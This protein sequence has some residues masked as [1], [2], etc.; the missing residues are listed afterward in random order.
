LLHS[1]VPSAKLAVDTSMNTT[2]SSANSIVA[3]SRDSIGFSTLKQQVDS[4][5]A[6]PIPQDISTP[7]SAVPSRLRMPAKTPAQEKSFNAAQDMST[8]DILKTP[9]SANRS[10][11]FA[12]P[13]D[14]RT[15]SQQ[16][17][18]FIPEQLKQGYVATHVKPAVTPDVGEM[19]P[20]SFEKYWDTKVPGYM[21]TPD[22]PYGAG[23]QTD[24]V[25]PMTKKV[26]KK[27]ADSV[28]AAF[29][30][31]SK[32]PIPTYT[33][34]E[35]CNLFKIIMIKFIAQFLLA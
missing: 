6:K 4:P 11:Q 17:T 10:V 22:T 33:A 25:S 19:T 32:A 12:T 20:R 1:D 14:V 35:V 28:P 18:P 29:K 31:N 2:L 16:Y 26:W 24:E 21:P 9:D 15:P 3:N 8:I 13:T 34:S 23:I 30:A 27:Y 5:Q 7:L